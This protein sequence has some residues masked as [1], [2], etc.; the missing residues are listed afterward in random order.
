MADSSPISGYTFENATSRDL[1]AIYLIVLEV[2]G[3]DSPSQCDHRSLRRV[4]ERLGGTGRDGTYDSIEQLSNDLGAIWKGD[5]IPW[6]QRTPIQR[7]FVRVTRSRRVA[8][9]LLVVALLGVSLVAVSS[10]K[11]ERLRDE[12]TLVERAREANRE[13]RIREAEAIIT[14]MAATAS[15]RFELGLTDESL[16]MLGLLQGQIENF[17]PQEPLVAERLSREVCRGRLRVVRS[18]HEVGRVDPELLRTLVLDAHE[19]GYW[20]VLMEEAGDISGLLERESE[21][22]RSEWSPGAM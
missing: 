5:P 17:V 21:R 15:S 6:I 11:L 1:A 4:I 22:L 14:T 3:I 2:M 12:E 19:S 16:E 9:L 18:Q 10:I 20:E 7:A 13:Y 8:A